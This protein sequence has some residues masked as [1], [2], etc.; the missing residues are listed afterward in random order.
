MM[1]NDPQTA[2][3]L[4][5]Y[6]DRYRGAVAAASQ[7][8]GSPVAEGVGGRGKGLAA[9]A[10][11]AM[12]LAV[13][14]VVGHGVHVMAGVPISVVGL[15]VLGNGGWRLAFGELRDGRTRRP[16]GWWESG[17][18]M[19]TLVGAFFGVPLPWLVSRLLG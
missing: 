3:H 17:L 14:I 6:L 2:Q 5:A 16:L 18:T 19:V 11:G 10:A 4:A 12:L 15:A 9:F 1:I 13:A 7:Q 8:L